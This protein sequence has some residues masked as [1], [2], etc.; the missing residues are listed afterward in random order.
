M[1]SI[2]KPIANMNLIQN[3]CGVNVRS[4]NH[5]QKLEWNQIFWKAVTDDTSRKTIM[6]NKSKPGIF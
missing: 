5:R 6:D 1:L 3:G 2:Y 4:H